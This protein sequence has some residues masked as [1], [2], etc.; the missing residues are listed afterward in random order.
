MKKKEINIFIFRR[1]LRFVDNTALNAIIEISGDTPILPIFIFNP[2][3]IDPKLN[4]YYSKNAVEFM[5]QCMNKIRDYIYLFEGSDKDI[6]NKLLNIFQINTIAFNIDY[7]PFA[8]DRDQ[9]IEKWG[10]EKNI[11]ILTRPDYTLLPFNFSGKAYEIFTPFYNNFLKNKQIPNVDTLDQTKFLKTFLYSSL[12]KNLVIKDTD[13]YYNHTP[14]VYLAIKGGRDN[15]LKIIEAIKHKQFSKYATQRDFPALEKTTKLS[16]YIKFGCISIREVY[17]AMSL[18][19][20]DLTREL[21]WR[22]FY[23]NVI[24]NKPKVLEGQ[25]KGLRNKCFKEQYENIQWSFNNNYWNAWCE[26]KTGVPFVDAGIRQLLLTGFCHNRLRMVLGMFFAKDMLMDWHVFENWMAKNLIDYDPSSNSG[27][28]QWCYSIGTD[29]APYYRI[30]NPYL[31]SER[32]DPNCDYIKKW[33]PE[34][35]GIPAKNIHRWDTDYVKF[36]ETNYPPPMLNH[37]KQIKLAKNIYKLMLKNV[38]K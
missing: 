29:A 18:H 9:I 3:Q 27:G 8:K 37:S 10:Q 21:I 31:Q 38:I 24:N 20:K 12:I 1:D 14:N 30:F 23:A 17:H 15:A 5:I 13:K 36:T 34:L 33:V 2:K 28:V 7:T 4:T 25:L 11:N 26:A 32:F 6:L 35:K 19:N 22:E 16:A